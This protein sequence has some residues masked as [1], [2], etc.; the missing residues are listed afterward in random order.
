MGHKER[1][2]EEKCIQE[3]GGVNSKKGTAWKTLCMD[4][5]IMLK[6]YLIG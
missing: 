1:E 4:D 6:S 3:S 5:R 2:T